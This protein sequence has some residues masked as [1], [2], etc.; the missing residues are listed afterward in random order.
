MIEKN[1]NAFSVYGLIPSTDYLFC[2]FGGD[3][4][5][6]GRV[7]LRDCLA[8]R[9]QSL[10]SERTWITVGDKNWTIVSTVL[11]VFLIFLLGGLIA[12][13]VVR[14]K[15]SLLKGSRRVEVVK[16]R[17]GE[18]V[19]VM[20]ERKTAPSPSPSNTYDTISG[21]IS[22]TPQD[23]TPPP[24]PPYPPTWFKRNKEERGDLE[25]REYLEPKRL[26]PIRFPRNKDLLLEYEWYTQHF[27]QEK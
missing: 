8:Y 27:R 4:I 20:P 2:V 10:P 3:G 1:S 21:Y 23:K 11:T 12:F 13:L 18:L 26:Y 6:T 7:D 14:R 25:A 19:L 15:P 24:L 22:L 16:S 9:T 5:E 17:N